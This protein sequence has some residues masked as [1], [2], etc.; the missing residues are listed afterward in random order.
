MSGVESYFH[1][2]GRVRFELGIISVNSFAGF[3]LPVGDAANGAREVKSR[4]KLSREW[5]CVGLFDSDADEDADDRR[6]TM[7]TVLRHAVLNVG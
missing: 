1:S 5:E 3:D 6:G 4:S 7:A 2:P